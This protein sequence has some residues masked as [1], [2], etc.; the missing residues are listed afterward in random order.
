MSVPSA[1]AW[2]HR[3]FRAL[4]VAVVALAPVEG[5]LLWLHPGLAKLP[6]ALLVVTWGVLRWRVRPTPQPQLIY[7][8]LASLAVIVIASSATHL[9]SPFATLYATRWLPFLVV[10]A[11]LIDVASALVG[12]RLLSVAT[13]VGATAASIGALCFVLVLRE[14]RSALPETDPN[15]LACALVAALPLL[16]CLSPRRTIERI[17]VAVAFTSIA[18]AAIA[19]QS[20]GGLIAVSAAFAWTMIRRAIPLRPALHAGAVLGI[21]AAVAAYVWRSD[22]ATAVAAKKYI[23]QYNA[24]TRL[25]RW[26]GALEL[27]G[28]HPLL[29]VG[30]GGFR[31]QYPVVSQMAEIDVPAQQFVAHNTYLEVAAELGLVGLAALL[32][33]L[34]TAFLG[35]E[36]ALRRGMDRGV[37]VGVQASVISAA[38]AVFF[39]SGQYFFALWWAVTL[40]CALGIRARRGRVV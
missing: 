34:A 32:A 30:P 26:H 6:A 40:G 2:E 36:Y 5:Y 7:V 24:D 17:A 22:I 14:T 20:R 38:V 33:V 13:V 29:G 10:T 11:I 28:R 27:V 35:A 12:V 9:T 8:L 19:T 37:A 3:L 23:G 4:A 25:L 21:A 15:D 31:D 16:L 39:L 1:V 18:L